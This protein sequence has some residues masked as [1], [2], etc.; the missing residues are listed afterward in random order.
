[1][2]SKNQQ[3]KTSMNS[4]F[5]NKFFIVFFALIILPSFLLGNVIKKT[6]HF[7]APEVKTQA[8]GSALVDFGTSYQMGLSGGP[9]LPVHKIALLL[10]PGHIATGIEV[11]FKSPMSLGGDIFLAPHQSPRPMGIPS[12]KHKEFNQ[13][14]YQQTTAIDGPDPAVHTH[15]LFGHAVAIGVISPVQY[16]P[17]GQDLSY[18]T[19]IEVTVTTEPDYRAVEALQFYRDD[20]LTLS[21]LKNLVDNFDESISLYP[22]QSNSSVYDYLIITTEEFKSDYQK[23]ANFYN[24]RG[25]KTRIATVESIYNDVLGSDEPEKIRNYIIQEAQQNSITYVLLAG[26]ADVSSL[27][28]MQ[29]PVRYFYSEVLSGEDTYRADIPSDLYYSALDGSWND[30]DD[31]HWGE[32]GED[33]LLP[34]L[35]VGRIPADNHQEIQAILNKI[36]NYQ[37]SPVVS[38][39]KNQLLAGQ[40]LWDDPLSF[41]ADYLDMLVGDHDDNGY[42]TYDLP[43]FL[44]LDYL[45]DRDVYPAH[46]SKEDLLREI[47]KGQNFIHHLGHSSSRGVMTFSL[48]DITNENF[49]DING[50]NHLN[51]IIYSEGCE[52][53]KIDAVNSDGSDCI[54]EKMLEIENFAVAFIGNTRYGWFNEGQTEGPSLHLHREFIDALFHDGIYSLGGAHAESRAQSAPFVTAP[55]EW[56][57]GALRWCFYGANVLGDPALAAWTGEIRDFENIALPAVISDNFAVRTN[58]PGATVALSID[59]VLIAA[60]H[61]DSSGTA[62]FTIDSLEIT[63]P[64]TVA[65]TA[66]NYKPYVTKINFD[67]NPSDVDDQLAQTTKKFELKNAYPNPF[68]PTTTIEFSTTKTG[69]VELAIYNIRGQ[70]IRTLISQTISAGSH[71]QIWDG[72]D[73]FG[74]PVPGGVYLYRISSAEGNK[75]KSCVLLK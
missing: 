57:P 20:A 74:R 45:Y 53:A 50:V 5:S 56:E 48:Y 55:D 44:N 41:G 64:V 69:F 68:N 25:L 12:A 30:D 17:A 52:A 49:K 66:Q 72:K 46:W 2:N 54:A 9:T 36:I 67:P 61:S 42:S 27:G 35:F 47:N 31:E 1:M 71:R 10:P 59:S 11:N 29:V 40:H 37:Q 73:D 28:Q 32:P 3:D 16:V 39:A 51:P 18:Y 38:D 75:T 65:I 70:K 34:E 43:S 23:L 7:S 62:F 58:V 13:Q 22:Q 26:D 33:D 24:V 60:A 6:Y 21:R 15:F 8:D 4:I 19:E 63:S 14:L